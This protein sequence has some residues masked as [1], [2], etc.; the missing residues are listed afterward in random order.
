VVHTD[1]KP[2]NILWHKEESLHP[3]SFGRVKLVD[4]GNALDCDEFDCVPLQDHAFEFQ[5]LIYRA[6][7]VATGTSISCAA[8][9]WSLGC[10]VLEA[11]LGTP[12]FTA[13]TRS[14]LLA[15][16]QQL[17]QTSLEVYVYLYIY[18]YIYS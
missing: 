13:T 10:I 3:S 18:I 7:E 15:Q 6:P 12:V 17:T 4:F 16:I 14:A 11:V 5:T 9:M 8:D 2:E 1:V